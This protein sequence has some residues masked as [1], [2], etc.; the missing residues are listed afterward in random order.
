MNPVMQ[1]A[2]DVIDSVQSDEAQLHA[3]R[4]GDL[5]ALVTTLVYSSQCMSPTDLIPLAV[6]CIRAAYALGERDAHSVPEAF[7]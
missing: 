2:L 1:Q 4:I 6:S 3:S 7:R 5:A